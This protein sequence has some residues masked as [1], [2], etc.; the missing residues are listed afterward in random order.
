MHV[1]KSTLTPGDLTITWTASLSAGAENYGIY[2]GPI[3]SPWTYGH[4]AIDC[5]DNGADFT[6]EVTPAS[7]SGSYF[8]LVVAL[9]PNHEGSY[10]RRTSG[11][12]RPTGGSPCRPTQDFDCP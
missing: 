3:T 9:N 2:E 6:E 10:G 5:F 12:E 8:Y 7:V 1:D 11:A 4:V